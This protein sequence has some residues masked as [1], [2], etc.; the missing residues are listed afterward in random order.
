M[1]ASSGIAGSYDGSISRFLRNH[2]V[3]CGYTNFHSYQQC[4]LVSLPLP[5]QCFLFESLGDGH[6]DQCEMTS[7]SGIDFHLSDNERC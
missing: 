5:L 2:T 1:Y 6:C 7:H 3:Y 4:K